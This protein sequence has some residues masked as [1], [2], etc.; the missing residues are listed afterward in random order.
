[1]SRRFTRLSLLFVLML[2]SEVWAIGLGDINLNSALNEPLR[3]EIVLLSASPDEL[4][5]LTVTLAS[6]ETF[7]R[8]GIDRP[9]YLQGLE[10][11]IVDAGASGSVVQIRSRAPITEPF[12]TFLVEAT[13]SSGRLLRE[14]TVLLD[15]PTYAAPAARQAPAVAAPRRSTPSDSGQ[16][17]RQP[18]PAPTQRQSR[19][20]PQPSQ[21]A[22][23]ADSSVSDSMVTDATVTDATVADSSYESPPEPRPQAP[24]DDSPYGTADGGDLIVQRGETLWG[25]TARNRPDGRLTMNQTM[26]AI[27]QANPDAFGGNINVLRAGASLRIPSADEVFQINRGDALS[28]VQRQHNAWSGATSYTAPQQT[29]RP[30]LTLVPPDEEPAGGDY[31]DDASTYEPQSRELQIEGRIAELEAADV[32]NQ[33]SLIEIRDNELAALRQELADIRGEVYEAPVDDPV[34]DESVDDPGID[35]IIV[36]DAD[37]TQLADDTADV[38]VD[39]DITTTPSDVISTSSSSGDK[40]IVD[41]VIEFLTGFWGIIIGAL[42]LVAGGLIWFMRRDSD[43]DDDNERP[44]ET[45]DSD[46]MAADSISVTSTM[47]APTP[48]DAIVV[49]EQDSGIHPIL[50]DTVEAPVADLAQGEGEASGAFG[51]LEDTF[52]SETAV[53][54]DQ[55]DP[56]AEA[57]FHMAYGLY[58]QAADLING[59]LETDPSDKALMSKLCEIYF[60]WGNRD[61]FVDAATRLKTAVGDDTSADWDKI[62]IM[63]QQIAA[64]H[65]LFAGAGVAGATK[66]VDLSF[67]DGGEADSALDMDFGADDSGAAEIIDLGAEDSAASD[68]IDLGADDEATQDAV[69]FNFD[70]PAEEAA[71]AVDF[72]L[73]VTAETPTI[74]STMTEATAEMPSPT[75]ATPTIED[76]F[77]GFSESTSE[78]PSLDEESLKDAIAASGQDAEATAEINLDE[79]D[80]GI[81]DLT[82]TE[83]ASLDD[84]DVTGQHEELSDTGINEALSELDFDDVTGKNPAIDVEVT[85]IQETLDPD[86][87]G[88]MQGADPDATGLVE[89]LDLGDLESSGMRLAADETGQNPMVT[90]E[91]EQE[92]TDV[93]IDDSL[94]DATGLT[95]VLSED[96]AVATGADLAGELSDVD[97]TLLA[98]GMGVDS[99]AEEPETML[100]PMDEDDD[101]DFAKTEALPSDAFTS[102][103]DLDATAETPA[104]AGTDVDLD[105]DDL[106]AALQV[107]EI[108]DTIEQSRDD[109]TVE[110]PRPT[111][112]EE[113]AEVPTMSLAPEDMSGDLHE[114][115]TM[116]EVG[117]KLDLARAYVDMGDP[118]GARSILEEV[119]DEGDGP[120]KQQAQQ[121]LD[122][123][124]S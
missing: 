51:S 21:P 19:P 98:P 62:V 12:L 82:E 4:S 49:V 83:V 85:G 67:D 6:D 8:Y 68:V 41:T 10:F 53:N 27:Y 97:A 69:D 32:P 115:R 3:A 50:E 18:T 112:S 104:I 45:L 90:A 34:V 109:A 110:Q 121:L 124:P 30:S 44:W 40:S 114:A 103:M 36:D 63:G 76:Q 13:W 123:L 122:S 7:V 54:L 43:D 52:S 77:E 116:T 5:D 91:A 70:E 2:T 14:Y 113:T 17:Q 99:P 11:N 88:T 64:D 48:E 75:V 23:A 55:T 47:Q 120:Q 58:D 107:S 1:M 117:T 81:D 94:L 106:T 100:A 96:M 28:E 42:V 79:L 31:D 65:D 101:F 86:A 20:A 80:L 56:I 60:V 89:G 71:D 16:I 24:V 73:E 102:N 46:E 57:D 26:L 37:D 105:L 95:Q 72:D 25:L 15:P 78:L 61:S 87:T 108:G 35:D 119:L 118:A 92:V 29:T 66:E 22:R 74:D 93:G 9:F 33:R 111:I 84:I 39:S 59:A 38:V